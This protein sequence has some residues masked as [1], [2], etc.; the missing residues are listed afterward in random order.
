MHLG[1]RRPARRRHRP[2]APGTRAPR[3]RSH[4]PSPEPTSSAPPASEAEVAEAA[5]DYY[6]AVDREDWAYTYANLDASTRALYAEDEWYLKNQFFAD[7]EG[8]ELA[9]MDVVV[10]GSAADPEVGVTV[11]RTFEDGTSIERYTLFV[12]EDGI[13]KH[14]FTAE[15]NA[16]FQPGVPYEDFVASQ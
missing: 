6:Q 13:W 7:T 16:I 5:E 8:L 11:Y 9:T 1:H 3:S 4:P 2:Q 12:Q 14:R 10:E 15:E